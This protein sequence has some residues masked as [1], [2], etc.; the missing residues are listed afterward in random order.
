MPRM[1][2]ELPRRDSSAVRTKYVWSA[3]GG[4]ALAIGVFVGWH[5]HWAHAL[6]VGVAGGALV[7]ASLRTV[8]NLRRLH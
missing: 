7:F 4:L 8:E 3:A 1:A 2:L 5:F 6:L